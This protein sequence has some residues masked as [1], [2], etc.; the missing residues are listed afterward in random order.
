MQDDFSFIHERGF[1]KHA[2][3]MN[4]RNQIVF[5]TGAPPT[6]EDVERIYYRRSGV[7]PVDFN[8]IK[9]AVFDAGYYVE[10]ENKRR[11]ANYEKEIE[12][13]KA[14]AKAKGIEPVIPDFI[15]TNENIQD[16]NVYVREELLYALINQQLSRQT[17]T[18]I[19][20]S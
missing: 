8:N 3:D 12:Q 4:K 7:R 6:I 15:P 9:M 10:M 20:T 19:K 1:T 2:S 13:I 17:A 16:G 18:S 11:R 14:N 5:N